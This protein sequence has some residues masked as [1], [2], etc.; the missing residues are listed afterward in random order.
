MKYLVWFS[1]F[2]YVCG[3][4]ESPHPD[5]G[6]LSYTSVDSDVKRFEVTA[7][8]ITL[9]QRSYHIFGTSL[10]NLA[11]LPLHHYSWQLFEPNL[12]I[13]FTSIFSVFWART[14]RKTR[15]ITGKR[16]GSSL[17]SISVAQSCPVFAPSW[18]ERGP[19]FPTSSW[20]SSQG[21]LH[22]YHVPIK[23]LRKY[24]LL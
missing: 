2:T 11:P 15:D 24:V 16:T 21:P 19:T 6:R 7:N 20:Q 23:F 1:C 14:F 22:P 17:S 13:D 18:E 10:K 5:N 8:F 4:L 3:L 9:I 12:M